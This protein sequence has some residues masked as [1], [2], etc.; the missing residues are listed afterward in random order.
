MKWKMEDVPLFELCCARDF[1][2]TVL[3]EATEE[4]CKGAETHR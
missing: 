4:V 3:D 2:L 1:G